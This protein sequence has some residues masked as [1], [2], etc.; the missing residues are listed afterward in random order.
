MPFGDD[1]RPCGRP[2]RSGRAVA[3]V[4]GH[5]GLREDLMRF[6]DAGREGFFVSALI[7]AGL[8]AGRTSRLDPC[9]SAPSIAA[10]VLPVWLAVPAGSTGWQHFG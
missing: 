1:L 2:R 4:V 8:H 5:P 6:W 7:V 10:V 9:G 3:A